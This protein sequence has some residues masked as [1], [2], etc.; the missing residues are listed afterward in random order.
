MN[1]ATRARILAFVVLSAVGIVYVAATYLGLVD[2]VLGRGFAVEA[3]LPTSGG[4]YVGSEVTYRGVGIGEVSQMRATRDGVTLRLSLEEGTEL[5]LDSSMQV[6]NLSA[7]GEQYL[8]FLPPDEDPPYASEGSVFA[9]TDRAL[10]VDEGALLVSLDDFVGSVDKSK[11]QTLV[12][13]LGDAFEGTG[14]PLQQLIDSG[15]RFVDEASAHTDETISLLDSALTVLNTQREQGQNISSFA[16]DLAALTASLRT[17][18]GDLRETLEGTPPTAREVTALLEDIEPSLR[19][20][21]G[22][23]SSLMGV[24]GGGVHLAGL[25]QLLVTFPRVIAGGF[26]GSPPDGYGHVNLQFDYSV[27]PCTQGY[28]PP[29]DWRRGNEL[30][31][32]PIFP[33]RCTAGSPF[34][35]RGTPNVPGSRT[36]PSPARS[37]VGSYDL[38]SG[39]V[40]PM[41]DDA[42]APVSFRVPP[43]LRLLGD[44]SWKWLLI[45]PV[46]SR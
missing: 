27:P 9:G 33:A 30:S 8:D 14:L 34:V 35:M 28:K 2:K 6:H 31:D 25:E 26:T 20:L 12:R 29:Q 11:L 40:A 46:N 23:T 45:G 36:N 7:V 38:D 18:D 10:P 21:L 37:Y 39:E 16:D 42:G 19:Q 3:Q 41:L 24:L 43:D 17:A 4:L 15:G 5:P 44:A 1:G 13:E 32:A 22:D